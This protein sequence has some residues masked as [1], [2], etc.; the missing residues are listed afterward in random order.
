MG[1]GGGIELRVFANLAEFVT[2]VTVQPEDEDCEVG[3]VQSFQVALGAAAGATMYLNDYTWGPV[4]QTSVPIWYTELG[5]ICAGTRS[6]P[7]MATTAITTTPGVEKRQDVSSTA[8]TTTTLTTTVI[9]TGV[10]CLSTGLVNCP[11]SLQN[12]TR[13][14]ATS[15]FVTVV[16]SDIDSAEITF[17]ASSQNAV[18]ITMPFGSNAMTVPVLP[19]GSPTSYTPPPPPPTETGKPGIIS[20]LHGDVNGVS[21][22]V[23][24]GVSVGLGVPIVLALIGTVM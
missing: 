24:I 4:A 21:Q 5:A 17:P 11:A 22:S 3:I 1:F 12:T 9:Y 8:L 10:N 23:I 15:T 19:S 6:S 2:N 7:T 16:P 14:E 13:F 20:T 18:P